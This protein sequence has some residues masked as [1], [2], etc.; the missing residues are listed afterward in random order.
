MS[1]VQARLDEIDHGAYPIELVTISLDP[2]NDT[3]EA[4]RAYAKSLRADLTNWHFATGPTDRLKMIVGGGF[5]I[6]F[7]RKEDGRLVYDP[8]IMLV[9]GVGILRAE[10]TTGDPGAERI[11]RDMQYILNEIENSEG[12]NKLAY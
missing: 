5:D 3:P 10:Y 1:E 12:A 4:L 7:D 8:A 6:Y 9:D 11:L 2:E